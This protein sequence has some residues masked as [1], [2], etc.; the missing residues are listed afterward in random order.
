MKGDVLTQIPTNGEFSQFHILLQK[1]L[2]RVKFKLDKIGIKIKSCMYVNE[3]GHFLTSCRSNCM[4]LRAHALFFS[5]II[6][7][8]R[9]HSMI[10]IK[11]SFYTNN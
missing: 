10:N 3:L 8:I 6:G 9:K 7:E 2:G 1:C 11:F 5:K 4:R